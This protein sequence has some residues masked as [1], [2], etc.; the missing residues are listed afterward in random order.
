MAYHCFDR[1][2]GVWEVMF[3][4]KNEG[5]YQFW[6]KVIMAYTG[7]HFQVY[8]KHVKHLENAEK[9]IFRFESQAHA[10]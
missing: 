5:A 7:N 8:V 4:P 2:V 6:K 9:K 3:M 1:F 10:S